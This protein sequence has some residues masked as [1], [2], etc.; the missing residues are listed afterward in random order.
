MLIIYIKQI[1]ALVNIQN[2]HPSPVLETQPHIDLPALCR[3]PILVQTYTGNLASHNLN[4]ASIQPHPGHPTLHKQTS[5]I[6][7]AQSYAGDPTSHVYMECNHI[8]VTQPH[9][10]SL[11]IN[12]SY[13][14]LNWFSPSASSTSKVKDAFAK[15][16]WLK[17]HKTVRCINDNK[18]LYN[19]SFYLRM[20]LGGL[21]QKK[22]ISMVYTWSLQLLR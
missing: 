6:Q 19:F 15:S 14:I 16:I 20:W 12:S 21:N 2:R 5:H 13:Q 11:H 18:W 8:Q 7:V 9:I 4:L 3:P 10:S 17:V 22:N 1:T